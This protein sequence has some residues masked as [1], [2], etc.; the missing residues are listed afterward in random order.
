MSILKPDSLTQRVVS[1]LHGKTES[2]VGN[3]ELVLH[4]QLMGTKQK[5]IKTSKEKKKK[6]IA[7]IPGKTHAKN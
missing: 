3:P 5:I 7:F 1:W 2:Q 4:S 6:K